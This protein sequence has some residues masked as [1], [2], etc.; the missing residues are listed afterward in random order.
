MTDKK[1]TKAERICELE[2][3]LVEAQAQQI[4]NH[5]F[6]SVG[7]EKASIN[8]CIGSAVIITITALGGREIV[9]PVAIRNGLSDATIKAIQDDLLRS[10]NYA[11]ELKPKG[12]TA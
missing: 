2:R 3:K 4:R 11:T 6:A 9:A 1:Q 8:K 12:A 10:F 7:I 5:H